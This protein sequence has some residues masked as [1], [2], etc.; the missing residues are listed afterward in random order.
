MAGYA[1]LPISEA[2]RKAL[3]ARNKYYE[4]RPD[5]RP[6]VP[7]EAL[8]AAPSLGACLAHYDWADFLYAAAGALWDAGDS[9]GG[10]ALLSDAAG[11]TAV[12][13][14]CIDKIIHRNPFE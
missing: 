4:D 11:E 3:E 10:A 14:A 8:A 7:D 1:D 2:H 13:H 9:A 5:E 12:G 6:K